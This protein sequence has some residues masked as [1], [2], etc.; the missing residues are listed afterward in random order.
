MEASTVGITDT[1]GKISP[2]CSLELE[3]LSAPIS[4][5]MYLPKKSQTSNL[6]KNTGMLNDGSLFFRYF[7]NLF[8]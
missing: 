5:L 1:E 2:E 6:L 7:A 8:F 4:L 3:L